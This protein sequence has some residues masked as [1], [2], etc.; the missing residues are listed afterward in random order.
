MPSASPKD[1]RRF[2]EIDGWRLLPSPRGRKRGRDHDH[3]E[4]TLADGTILR[5]KVSRDRDEYGPDLWHRIWRH[6]LALQTE[7]DFRRALRTR[8]PVSRGRRAPTAKKT[9][10]IPGWLAQNLVRLVHVPPHELVGM[11]LEE[12][13][14]RWR[15][16]LS[17]PRENAS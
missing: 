3:F 6:Q 15:K 13:E 2:C 1:H 7:E 8:R 9:P 14:A 11:T 10:R 5:T 16:Y 4:K 12:A 17:R